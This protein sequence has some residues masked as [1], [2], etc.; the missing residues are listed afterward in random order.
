MNDQEAQAVGYD[1]LLAAGVRFSHGSL[2]SGIEGFGLGAAMCGI[3]TVWSCEF[4]EF[5]TKIIQKNFGNEHEINRDI[6]NYSNPKPV[7]IVSGGFPCQDIS[8]AGK[9]IGITGER[10]GLWSEMFRIVGQIR[11]KYIIIENSP[12][13]LVRGFERVLCDLSKI[14]YD[15]EWQCLS[16]TDFGIQQGRERLYVVA[17]PDKVNSER[18]L[19]ES[20]F[21]KPFL[22]GEHTRVYPGWRNRQSLPTSR[23]SG[24]SNDVPYRVD[25]TESVGNAVQP[26]VAA[27]LFRCILAHSSYACR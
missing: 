7:D 27:Y 25:R 4:E 11:P 20:V 14:G 16:G 9:G 3:K 23:F 26:V 8:I 12:M 18:S 24:K 13:L 21:R 1:R 6:R 5:Q 19:Q 15:A 10:S 2:F 22:Q 17:Y